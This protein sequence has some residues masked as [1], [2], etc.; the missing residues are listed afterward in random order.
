MKPCMCQDPTHAGTKMK[1][2]MLKLN[3]FLPMGDYF[4][5]ID[6]LKQI[7]SKYPKNYHGMT[8][9]TLN[10]AD[11]MNFKSVQILISNKV[12]EC[13][14]LIEGSLA[15]QIYLKLIQFIL[16]SYLDKNLNILERNYKIWYSLFFI[17][18][19]RQW[20]LSKKD[21]PEKYNLTYNFLTLNT[22]TCIE[23]DAHTM[24]I[25]SKKHVEKKSVDKFFPWLLGSQTCEGWFRAARS[26]TSTFSTIINFTAK[27]FV[28]RSR[29]I[30][31]M[32]EA[33][34]DL[35]EEY[36]F[37]RSK[38]TG[39]QRVPHSEITF[40]NIIDEIMKAKENAIN[41]IKR[42]GMLVDD[43][44]WKVCD[45][46][47]AGESEE[48]VSSVSSPST[49][50]LFNIRP[51]L[52]EQIKHLGLK[53]I[54]TSLDDKKLENSN[55]VKVSVAGK[56]VIIRKTCLVW[57]LSEKG[58]RVSTDR[59]YRFKNSSNK[60][61]GTNSIEFILEKYYAVYYE[62]QFY[63]GRVLTINGDKCTMKFL[64]KNVNSYIWPKK[65]DICDVEI[66]FIYFGPITLLGN[67][68]F[69]INTDTKNKLEKLYKQMKSNK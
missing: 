6:H 15:T 31:F 44:S 49:S 14:K 38:Q 4:V 1:T 26:L 53:N 34:F 52:V 35:S 37:P 42:L 12:Q 33:T 40:D 57:I 48:T 23:I 46:N 13:L 17:R 54:E 51:E 39:Q 20:I 22:Y 68:P 50:T 24:L 3:I 5:D 62:D 28:E 18:Q 63:I 67:H 8:L 27:E 16:D 21:S 25:L 61:K 41:D 55:L 56:S 47:V 60:T 7:I 69:K 65:D 19:W 10:H 43:E 29:K 36:E 32:H 58:E 11:K 59:I 9:S 2:R 45:L 64:K 66:S 30:E